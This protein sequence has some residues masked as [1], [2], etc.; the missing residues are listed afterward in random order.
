MH[1][2]AFGLPPGPV[3][4]HVHH[5]KWR[6]RIA[7]LRNKTIPHYIARPGKALQAGRT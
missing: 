1:T 4:A 2:R 7:P 5:W 6:T 3:E